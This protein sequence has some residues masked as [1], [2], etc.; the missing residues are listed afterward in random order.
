MKTIDTR[1]LYK[2][3][4]ELEGLKTTLET[5][6]E[7]LA[8]AEKELAEAIPGETDD[9]EA[10]EDAKTAVSDA[11]EDFGT[12]EAEE[13]AEL[14]EL[15]NEIGHSAMKDGETMVPEHN[16]QEYARQF[17]EDIGAIPDD[18]QW[19][20]TCIDWEKAAD[21]LRQDY[22]SVTYQGQD[23]YVRA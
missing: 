21:E 23:Y 10:V 18:A 19:P 14:E 16:F 3:K 15:E 2:R 12:D 20:C 11:E 1:D 13:L 22:T 8:E 9:P 17:A 4:N 5:A 6:R 7:E